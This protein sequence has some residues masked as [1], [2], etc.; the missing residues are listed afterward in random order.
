MFFSVSMT[1]LVARICALFAL[2][3][4]GGC[5]RVSRDHLYDGPPPRPAA[6]E[7]YYAPEQSYTGYREEIEKATPKFT[8]KHITVESYAGPIVIDYFQTPKQSDALVLVFPVLGGKNFIERH[9]AKYFAEA[10]FDAA[11]V[12]RSNE[13]KD[14]AKFDQLEEIFRLNVIR[15]RLALDFF[16]NE[17]GKA[18]VGTFGISRGAINVALTAG[19][20]D[21]LKYNVLVMGGT[22]LV[23]LFRD[24]NQPRISNYIQ[25]VSEQKGFVQEQFFEA[26]RRQL[27]TDPKNTARY[28][29]GRD[30]LLILGIF[31][32]TVPFRYGLRL[33]EQIGRP[34][35][36][37]LL[38]DHY[39]GVLYSQTVSVVPPS[40]DGPGLFP[41]PY[42]EEEALNFYDR[43]FNNETHWT[44]IPYR[45]LQTPVNL[46]AEGFAEVGS[47]F[48][49]AFD[50]DEDEP[51]DD[52]SEESEQYWVEALQ[53]AAGAK[54]ED[55]EGLALQGGT[56]VASVR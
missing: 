22:D 2:L 41:F 25:M 26:L 42:V 31:D 14:P 15:D 30:T 50:S 17:Y 5:F 51:S 49:W 29:D 3:H 43:H 52:E 40:K 36:V 32:R 37:F 24:S 35:T 47:F 1:R 12:N 20:D 46:L 6:M 54:P 56:G 28:L 19:I 18:R 55:A 8:I 21:R 44:I 53:I 23:D 16:Q 27:R 10:G 13:F 7:R 11:I 39:V 38:A 4:T 9:M 45:I 33:R 48:E 34:E